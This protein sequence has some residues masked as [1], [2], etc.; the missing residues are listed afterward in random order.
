MKITKIIDS[1]SMIKWDNKKIILL[2]LCITAILYID[3]SFIMKPQIDNLKLLKPKITELKKDID[4]LNKD[5]ANLSKF[6]KEQSNNTGAKNIKVVSENE[7]SLLLEDISNIANKNNVRIMQISPS[8]VKDAK[9]GKNIKEAKNAKETKKETKALNFTTLNISLDL[10]SSYHNLGKFINDLENGDK[11]LAVDAMGIAP[12][13][14]NY[15]RH[16]ISLVLKT[17]VKK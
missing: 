5:L 15:L 13:K 10:S 9:E 4:D 12:V 1:F 2:I 3:Y 17:Y 16:K 7:L 8:K 14:D 11:F 6:K